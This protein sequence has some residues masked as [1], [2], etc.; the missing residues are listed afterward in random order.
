MKATY[1]IPVESSIIEMFEGL[2]DLGLRPVP[3]KSE[4]N[5]VLEDCVVVRGDTKDLRHIQELAKSYNIQGILAILDDG[6]KDCYIVDTYNKDYSFYKETPVGNW[7]AVTSDTD[8]YSPFVYLNHLG[9]VYT[10]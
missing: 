5:E 4:H 3:C 2:E 1:I 10:F 7:K 9:L 6:S 8:N